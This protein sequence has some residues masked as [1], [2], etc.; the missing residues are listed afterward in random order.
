MQFR[1]LESNPEESAR[2]IIGEIANEAELDGSPLSDWDVTVLSSQVFDFPDN[3][4]HLLVASH[5]LAVTLVR[6]AIE[7]AKGTGVPLLK[8]REGLVIP[9]QWEDHY[10]TL[11]ETEFPWMVSTV[12]QSA[13]MGNPLADETEAWT[14]L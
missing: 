1:P 12:M 8:V 10:Q 4:R 14:S 5:N 11:Y 13:F 6:S 9:Q 3:Q 2:W 7:R